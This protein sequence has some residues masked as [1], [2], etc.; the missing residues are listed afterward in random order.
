MEEKALLSQVLH[1]TVHLAQPEHLWP[2]GETST[3]GKGCDLQWDLEEV[4]LSN[5]S[6]PGPWS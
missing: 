2:K 3:T 4:F 6:Y 1:G 5:S